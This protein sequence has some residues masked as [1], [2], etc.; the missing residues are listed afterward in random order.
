MIIFDSMKRNIIYFAAIGMA[1]L[2][3][4]CQERMQE[5]AGNDM[6]E[7]HVRP[8]TADTKSV[9]DVTGGDIFAWTYGTGEA[10][11][12]EPVRQYAIKDGVY[13]YL[14]PSGT[15]QIIFSNI[16]SSDEFL[17]GRDEDGG[18]VFSKRNTGSFFSTD[19]VAGTASMSS[20]S[21]EGSLTVEMKRLNSYLTADLQMKSPDGTLLELAD[22]M[23]SAELTLPW[24]AASV[25]FKTDGT[26]KPSGTT[27]LGE[28]PGGPEIP[29]EP[30]TLATGRYFI[31]A[32]GNIAVPLEE[33]KTSGYIQVVTDTEENRTEA[34]LFTFTQT[35]DGYTIQDS[36]GRYIYM[37]DTST[38]SLYAAV[39]APARGH[40][41]NVEKTDDGTW[42]IT[43]I[44]KQKWIQYS[45]AYSNFECSVKTSGIL[46]ELVLYVP[47]ADEEPSEGTG[48]EG[49]V[50]TPEEEATKAGNAAAG[51]TTYNLCRE[52]ATL[53]TVRGVESSILE[54][55]I[56]NKSGNTT[57]IRKSIDTVFEP[58][59]HYKFTLVMKR[60]ET[61]FTFTVEDM[62]E[63]SID[64][65]LN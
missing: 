16:A 50:T 12:A 48:E 47:A 17:A 63:E 54:L 64:I 45:T 28:M 39:S 62:I 42:K 55:S 18:L 24:Q 59:R 35:E 26:V 27:V 21:E 56:L 7:I 36:Y 10:S 22:F 34:N 32:E 19:M 51:Q 40:V 38:S 1:F 4:S 41:W 43:N 53:P 46:P 3:T 61:G 11:A 65:D 57:V 2:A 20:I 5:S 30:S 44:L 6:M 23:Q 60:N 25:T 14:L 31:T 13:S 49:G 8:Y 58:N 33:D 15:E 52:A 37:P 29:E 9:A